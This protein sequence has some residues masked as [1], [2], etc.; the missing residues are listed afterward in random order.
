VSGGSGGSAVVA[1]SSD[2]GIGFVIGARL[3]LAAPT[4]TAS[5]DEVLATGGTGADLPLSDFF[6]AGAGLELHGGVR[7][8]R[9]VSGYLL[10]ER[11]F[12]QA[13]R[14]LDD[15]T[16]YVSE[17][18]VTSQTGGDNFGIGGSYD[19]MTGPFRVTGELALLPIH[20]YDA[21]QSVDASAGCGSHKNTLSFSGNAG[22]LG[23]VGSVQLSRAIALTP[24][25]EMTFGQFSHFE[26]TTECETT[27]AN[28]FQFVAANQTKTSK[29]LG[30]AKTHTTLFLGVG[31]DF[32]FG[33]SNPAK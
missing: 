8:L 9:R 33:G 4:G 24:T 18:S 2:G 28:P 17:V 14:L 31:V 19:F 27:T 12:F 15:V 16:G 30:S 23:V 25:F 21:T 6:G 1:E 5:T 29:D 13:G 3:G 22:R 11:D 7:F 20:K 26:A 10:Y 32:Y